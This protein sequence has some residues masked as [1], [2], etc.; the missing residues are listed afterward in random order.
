MSNREFGSS[1]NCCSRTNTQQ[2]III[3]DT[4]ETL[5][6]S[7]KTDLAQSAY[8]Q[9]DRESSTLIHKQIKVAKESHSG[10]AGEYISAIV[11][12]GL[13]G[14]ITT[15]AIVSA[16]AASHL[17]RSVI[18]IIGFANILGDAVGMAVGDYVSTKAEMDHA[19]AAK[20][21]E[22]RNITHRQQEEKLSLI[23]VYVSKGLSRSDAERVVAI[24]SENSE[25]FLEAIMVEKL[26]FLSETGEEGALKEA[27][28][29]F[30]AFMVFGGLPLLAYICGGN[31]STPGGF[32][33]V[34]GA[35]VA[36]F[37]IAL[38]TLGAIK[39]K[40]GKKR[41]WMSGLTM[42]LNGAITTALSYVLGYFLNEA[43]A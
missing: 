12:G 28:I 29:T 30:G 21:K 27:G 43:L 3:F 4:M 10:D 9:G 24:L 17:T 14:I 13:D 23:E 25:V 37:A 5:N 40:I 39:G 36:L 11:F 32:D 33:G 6:T 42:L 16:A 18:L 7:N 22:E 38:F 34:Y 20:T 31:Y 15:F 26:G 41:W 8:S 2:L 1:D 19:V 35:S